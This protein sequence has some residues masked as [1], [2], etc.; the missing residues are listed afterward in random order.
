MTLTSIVVRH[1]STVD[2]RDARRECHA[3]VVDKHVK[4]DDGLDRGGYGVGVFQIDW[5]GGGAEP[6]GDRVEPVGR[7]RTE[8]RRVSG[9]E[10]VKAIAEPAHPPLRL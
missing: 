5:P 7:S 4:L 1:S 10:R 6:F 8:K 2:F 3:R 9:C